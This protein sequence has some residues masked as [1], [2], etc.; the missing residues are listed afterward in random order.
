MAIPADIEAN[1]L[2]FLQDAKDASGYA[3][4]VMTLRYNKR[5]LPLSLRVGDKVYINLHKGYKVN[6]NLHKKFGARRV[7]RFPIK[8]I[9]ANGNA[10]E[11]ALPRHWK[12]HPVI[13]VEHIEPVPQGED[14]YN[15]PTDDG[16]EVQPVIEE[17]DTEEWR[18]WEIEKLVDKR[19]IRYGKGKPETEYLVQW[20]G[21][22]PAYNEW[23]P[24]RLLQNAKELMAEYDADEH[25]NQLL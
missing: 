14:P 3:Q 16:K 13:S 5:H 17:G 18:S 11:L 20:K 7:G 25:P 21:F 4:D 6:S 24:V 9:L 12:I 8:R 19:T 1:R 2:I 23:Y 10:Y 15:R 22:G